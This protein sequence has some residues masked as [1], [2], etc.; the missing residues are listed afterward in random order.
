MARALPHL[1]LA[2]GGDEFL[3]VEWFEVG[4]VLEVAGAVGGYGRLQHRRCFRPALAEAGVRVPDDVGAF[5][6]AVAYEQAWTCLLYTS[7]SPRD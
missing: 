4:D 1:L 2:D 5:A 6:G 3:E 7:P